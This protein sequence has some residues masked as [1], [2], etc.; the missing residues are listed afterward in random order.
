MWK[1]LVSKIQLDKRYDSRSDEHKTRSSA[2]RKFQMSQHDG[3][4]FRKPKDPFNPHFNLMV[5]LQYVNDPLGSRVIWWLLC[6]IIL[7]LLEDEAI[8]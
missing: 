6:V 5:N 7:R 3:F 2:Q 4:I 1:P 8:L